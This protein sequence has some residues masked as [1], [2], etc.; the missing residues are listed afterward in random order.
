M[1]SRYPATPAEQRRKERDPFRIASALEVR[2]I[3]RCAN[4]RRNPVRRQGLTAAHHR[5]PEHLHAVEVREERSVRA[6]HDATPSA[7]R[8]AFNPLTS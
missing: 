4:Q 8:G 5:A 3:A 7:Q 6:R 1:R 2:L